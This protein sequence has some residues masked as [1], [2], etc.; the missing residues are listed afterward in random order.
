MSSTTNLTVI[1][2]GNRHEMTCPPDTTLL[3]CV[4][5]HPGIVQVPHSCLDGECGACMAMLLQGE[6]YMQA[7]RVL[8]QKEQR[9]G[10]ILT[11]QSLP[12]SDVI[13]IDYDDA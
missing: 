1:F 13:L 9:K 11:C 6:V 5:D 3:D 2:N 12:R 10:Y 4:L 8:S 7:N